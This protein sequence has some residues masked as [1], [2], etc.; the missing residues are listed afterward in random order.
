MP[1]QESRLSLQEEGSAGPVSGSGG[2]MRFVEFHFP[3]Q[4][5]D[6]I[7]IGFPAAMFAWLGC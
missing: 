4:K 5:Q 1:I 3:K 7:P 2:R 6:R